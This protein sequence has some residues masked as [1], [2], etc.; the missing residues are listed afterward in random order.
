[1][2]LKFL[3]QEGR[4]EMRTRW[5]E[6]LSNRK[7][8]SR[9]A[10]W[11]LGGIL[12]A[13]TLICTVL[14]VWWSIEPDTFAP[15][16]TALHHAQTRGHQDA[17][18]YT[19][20]F[21]L[22]RMGETLLEKSGGFITNDVMPP[23]AFLDNIGNWEF[24]VLTQIR[25]MSRAMR[26][27]FSRS[28]SQSAED[29]DLAKAESMFF[30]DTTHWVLP[31]AEDE[32][33]VG[34]RHLNSYLERLGGKGEPPAYF[35]PRADNLRDWLVGVANRLGSISQRLSAS[36]GKR[37]LFSDAEPEG[38]A[39]PDMTFVKT[40]WN[41]IDDVFFEARGHC[42]ALIHLL[43]AVD[44][45]F[46]DVLENKNARVSLQQVIRELEPT[47]RTVWSPIILNADGFGVFANHSLV[48]ASYISRANAAITDL[49]LLLEQG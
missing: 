40:P 46:R 3:T 7:G 48:M 5:Q 1:M 49:R 42:W 32:Y 22:M 13:Y 19:T 11:S 9:L 29:L 18:G 16:G 39:G 44:H 24:G 20:T 35:Y 34:I 14:G 45:D 41:K 2:A 8:K 15:R 47:T 25:D 17:V 36:V 31:A 28:Q 12:A 43:E 21:T 10:L 23:G 26:L 30:S 37:A 6:R 33:G 38:Q 4:E 27:D